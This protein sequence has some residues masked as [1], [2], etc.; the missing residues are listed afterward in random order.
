MSALSERPRRSG[1]LRRD[2]QGVR[3]KML[4]QTLRTLEG[5]GFV[6]P[7]AQ[8]SMLPHIEFSPT[9]SGIE[10]ADQLR[11]L[12]GWIADNADAI[13]EGQSPDAQSLQGESMPR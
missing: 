13:L 12:I 5:D 2:V 8:P 10:L 11:P 7:D 9:P 4:A 3:D 1:D 6:L